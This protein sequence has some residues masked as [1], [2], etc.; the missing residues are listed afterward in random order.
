MKKFA[1]TTFCLAL[2]TTVVT[3]G[4]QEPRVNAQLDQTV[5]LVPQLGHVEFF[6][7]GGLT[8][9][10]I[11]PDKTTIATGGGDG[12]I[13]VFDISSWLLVRS[14]S[15]HLN[16]VSVLAYSPDGRTLASG[17]GDG[18]VH[19]WDVQ[20]GQ[21]IR[22]LEGHKTPVNCIS[23][24]LD[25]Q[26]LA[27]GS[28]S[29]GDVGAIS[30]NTIRLWNVRSGESQGI[31]SGHQASVTSLAFNGEGTRLL[32]GS[33][34]DTVRIWSIS[35]RRAL[36]MIS[37]E[38]THSVAFSPDGSRI[39]GAKSK[40]I[41]F[42]NANTGVQV[43]SIDH[44][45]YTA[46]VVFTPDWRILVVAN[47]IWDPNSGVKLRSLQGAE[48]GDAAI[49]PDGSLLVSA[50]SSGMVL[51]DVQ[52]GTPLHV[53]NQPPGLTTGIV[54]NKTGDKLA[55]GRKTQV[56]IW[57][58]SN[59]NLERIITAHKSNV[60]EV[61]FSPDGQTLVSCS[62][63]E[64]TVWSL[65]TGQAVH[66]LTKTSIQTVDGFQS[67][68]FSP[69]GKLL[70]VGG[71]IGGGD[72]QAAI[73]IWNTSTWRPVRTIAAPAPKTVIGSVR[74]SLK[75]HAAD[76]PGGPTTEVHSLAF[77]PDGRLLASG[78]EDGNVIVWSALTGRKIKLL[79]EHDSAVN[80]VAFNHTGRQIVSG[81]F[82][83]T[84][85]IWD[86]ATGR[87]IRTLKPHQDHVTSVRFSADDQMVVSGSI[88]RAV[89]FWNASDGK[90]LATLEG[91]DGA[92]TFVAL[93][94][95]GKIVASTGLDGRVNIWST[96]AKVL[97][98]TILTFNDMSWI[99][100]S[101]DGFYS[102]SPG[103]LNHVAWR[104]GN[105]ISAGSTL[106]AERSNPQLLLA[107]LSGSNPPV[108]EKPREFSPIADLGEVTPV[109]ESEKKLIDEWKNHRFYALVIGNNKYQHLP[110]LTTAAKDATDLARILEQRFDFQVKPLIDATRDE[111]MD[112]LQRLENLP[113]ASSVLI[114]YAGHGQYIDFGAQKEGVWQPVDADAN[115][116]NRWIRSSEILESIKLN[117]SLHVLIISDSCFSGTLLNRGSGNIILNE[118]PEVLFD[119][120]KRPSWTLVAS[121]G[122]EPV[123]DRGEDGHSV[124]TRALL[125]GFRNIPQ[126]VFTV[127]YLF[128][129]FIHDQVQERAS[130]E[131]RIRP[132]PGFDDD[133]KFIF[134]RRKRS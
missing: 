41:V 119:L 22:K 77:S 52:L 19:L 37:T 12:I 128:H 125:N 129:T 44:S 102:S 32:S 117:S 95:N 107:R 104:V 83:Q 70:A 60:N 26:T 31:L 20:T 132:I 40:Q 122:N 71:S 50:S 59:G 131:P 67:V 79:N 11:S 73:T 118:R 98:S 84:V 100:Y 62:D 4:L 105:S 35:D 27:S 38:A 80:S 63:D 114:F 92:V 124:F 110:A 96:S 5:A 53:F 76:P 36:R 29:Y 43:R 13:K 24:T 78:D 130:Q 46:H 16:G 55:W 1:I 81:S 6:L 66:D 116:R 3:R 93:S 94:P 133:G 48:N 109:S 89:R 112:E 58:L 68:Q 69:N 86:V 25:G 33:L 8:A 21:L 28:G 103:A 90:Q 64:L 75:A 97:L 2:V 101:P 39:T 57:N 108:I 106:A 9:V 85:K 61:A 54:F 127:D 123:D 82:D 74:N 111:I 113:K 49:T 51:W 65:Q 15:A 14:F 30:D 18:R 115:N 126:N 121:G 10:A 7:N 56:Y 72:D 91:H 23:F 88:D 17:G 34:D 134:M 99:D 45:H 120:M 42:W 47:E 87:S